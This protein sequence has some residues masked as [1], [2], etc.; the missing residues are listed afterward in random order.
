MAVSSVLLK[1]VHR[2]WT[3]WQSQKEMQHN[4]MCY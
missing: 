3:D 4:D 2:K 1:L